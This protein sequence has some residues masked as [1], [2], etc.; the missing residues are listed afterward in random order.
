MTNSKIN[1]K[2][3]ENKNTE[4]KTKDQI[5]NIS[6]NKY[7]VSDLKSTMDNKIIE[8]LESLN[9][10]ENNRYSNLKIVIGLYC[11]F[12]TCVAYLNGQEFPKNYNLICVSL[13]FYFLGTL[14]YWYV[15]SY[16]IKDTLYVGFNKSKYPNLNYVKL[17]SESDFNSSTKE[18]PY[19]LKIIIK[20]NNNSN[21]IVNQIKTDYNNFFDI[22]GYCLRNKLEKFVDDNILDKL[23]NKKNK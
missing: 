15:E 5:N 22:R 11:I 10:I 1:D 6:I 12:W 13:V 23:T 16:I 18:A 17:I 7:S 4:I 2:S 21:E 14:L 8:Y 20:E 3:I 19:N 9:F